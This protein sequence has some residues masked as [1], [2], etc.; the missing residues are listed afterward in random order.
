[1]GLPPSQLLPIFSP[2]PQALSSQDH[3]PTHPWHRQ[4]LSENSL[5]TGRTEVTEVQNPL[6]PTHWYK[7]GAQSCRPEGQEA[8]SSRPAP[9]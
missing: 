4:G 3:R 6:P 7:K 1:M 9:T 5:R 2:H 8:G